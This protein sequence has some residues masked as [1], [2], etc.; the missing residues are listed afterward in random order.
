[1]VTLS[2]WN[3]EDYLE[4]TLSIYGLNKE[5]ILISRWSLQYLSQIKKLKK[6]Q[7]PIRILL[8]TDK[9]NMFW[10]LSQQIKNIP[11]LL[12]VDKKVL[13]EKCTQS[14]ILYNPYSIPQSSISTSSISNV[15]LS[16]S[17][18]LSS[19]LVKSTNLQV[20]NQSGVH[21]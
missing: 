20:L 14:P 18:D 8:V 9:K 19:W 5:V 11:F 17:D 1:M 6:K 16:L 15:S 2:S 7:Q 3:I 12:V 4:T 13:V 10:I 21:I